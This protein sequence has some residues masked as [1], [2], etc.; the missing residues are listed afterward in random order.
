MGLFLIQKTTQPQE[1]SYD[2]VLHLLEIRKQTR[3]VQAVTKP[4]KAQRHPNKQQRP[5]KQK[6]VPSLNSAEI[7]LFLLQL[8]YQIVHQL[9]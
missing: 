4:N 2:K 5:E 1:K 6:E 3:W 7:F 9:C 8:I